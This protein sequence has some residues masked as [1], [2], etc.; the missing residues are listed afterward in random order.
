M[1]KKKQTKNKKW[2]PNPDYVTAKYEPRVWSCGSIN[3]GPPPKN[4]DTSE[5][6]TWDGKGVK[7]L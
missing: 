3:I 4:I 5:L 6:K 2:I 7:D 1:K